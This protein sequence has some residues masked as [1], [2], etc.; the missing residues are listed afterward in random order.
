MKNNIKYFLYSIVC[1]L[2]FFS[3]VKANEPFIFDVTEIQIS[4]DGNQI[5]GYKGG[6]VTTSDGDKIN[7]EEFS[8]NK[9]TN[10]LEATGSVKFTGKFDDIIIYSDKAN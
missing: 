3:N 5:N 10:I 8:Y 6:I 7:A 9:I 4:N 2:I 1:Y